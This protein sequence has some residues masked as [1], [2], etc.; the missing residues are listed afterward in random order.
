MSDPLQLVDWVYR[1]ILRAYPREY[2][3]SFGEEMWQTFQ[4]GAGEAWSQ[5]NLGLFVLRELLDMP[6][7]IANVYWI[8]WTKRL[9][10]GLQILQEVTSLDDL[11]PTPP[12]GR[13][14]WWQV[15]LEASPFL[16]AGL[17]L[18]G[19]NYFF[20]GGLSPG[21]QRGD[22]LW[23]TSIVLF[24]VPVFLIGLLRGLPRWAYPFGGLF[25]G[26]QL[27]LAR[28]TGAW[29]FLLTMLFISSVLALVAIGTDP[30]PALL[31][32]SLR[33]I[34]QSLAAGWT[35]LCFA[36]YGAMPCVI[37]LAYDDSH[38]NNQTPY[39]FLSVLIM[40]ICALLYSRSREQKVQVVILLVGLTLAIFGA[41]L[42]QISVAHRFANWLL[43]ISP[44]RTGHSWLLEL[45][46]QWMLLMV[47]PSILALLGKVLKLEQ[48]I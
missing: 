14:S 24:S 34:R 1:L 19:A 10:T 13:N 3:Q 16:M 5:G 22:G 27:L 12:D 36:L 29:L 21:W 9:S 15:M 40:V 20:I 4:E 6:R 44:G 28:Q 48:A 25:L 2:L 42:D 17:F 43:V 35:R 45:W 7:V 23:G 30:H 11:P 39:L 31:P 47:L 8:G 26:Y 46:V 33:R 37:L 38:S 18:I 32:A 41:V